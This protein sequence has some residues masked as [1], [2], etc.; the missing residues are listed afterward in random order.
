MHL[1]LLMKASAAIACMA[2]RTAASPLHQPANFCSPNHSASGWEIRDIFN[3]YVDEWVH[4]RNFS[5]AAEKYLS[6]DLIQHNPQI[7]N[8]SA[9]MVAAVIPILANY[10]GPDFSLVVVDEKKGLAVTLNRYVGKPGTGL[11]FAGVADFYRFDGTCIVEHWDVI[12]SLP[13]N[14][15]NPDPF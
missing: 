7:A 6:P 12:E 10:D 1:S 11:P 9:A 3:Q 8:G 14:S 5:A 13:A 15:T 4:Q 2:I